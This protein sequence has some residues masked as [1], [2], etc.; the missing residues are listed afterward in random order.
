MKNL[1]SVLALITCLLAI[2][3]TWASRSK[4]AG[5]GVSVRPYMKHSGTYVQGYHRSMPHKH[6]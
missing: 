6:L 5:Y 2:G 1:I 4:Q 3:D